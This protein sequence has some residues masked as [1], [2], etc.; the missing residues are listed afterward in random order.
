MNVNIIS[1]P[2][3]V[4]HNCTVQ[5]WY[6]QTPFLQRVARPGKGPQLSKI[7]FANLLLIQKRVGGDGQLTRKEKLMLELQT[8]EQKL[9]SRSLSRKTKLLSEL[10]AIDRAIE[11]KSKKLGQQ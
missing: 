7:T 1:G 10:K 11:K 2:N 5:V 4:V 9:S 6:Q 3:V 8:I